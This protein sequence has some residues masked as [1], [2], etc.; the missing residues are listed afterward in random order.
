MGPN[1]EREIADRDLIVAYANRQL[2]GPVDGE[3]EYLPEQPHRRYLTGMLFP[4]ASDAATAVPLPDDI[5]DDAAGDVPGE[6]GEDQS[7]DPVSLAGQRLPS[8]VGVSFILPARVPIRI[9]L[10]AAR[11]RPE[12]I[13]WKR[14]PISLADENAV[15]ISPP[16][17]PCKTRTPVLDGA[18]TIDVNW[19]PF[20]GDAQLV[21]VTLVNRRALNEHGAA[22]PEDCLFQVALRC[23]PASGAIP[24]YPSVLGLQSDEEEEELAL[25]YRDVPTFAIGHGAA[26]VWAEERENEVDW[27]G[28]SYLPAYSVPQVNFTLNT[29][30]GVLSL[31]RL[32]G[33]LDDPSAID[34]LHVFVDG[35]ESWLN[36]FQDVIQQISPQFSEAAVRITSRVATAVGRMRR[37]VELLA[38]DEDPDMKTA[39]ALANRAML[40]QMAHATEAYAGKRKTRTAEL[41]PEPDYDGLENAWRP[42]QLAFLLLTIESAAHPSSPDRE[43][44]D[45]IWFP[46]GGGKTEAYLA[47]SAFT[48]FYRRLTLGDSGAGTAVMTRYTLRLLT[49]QQ[50]QRASTL[51]CACEVIR[52][53]DPGLLGSRPISIGIWIGG[54]NSPNTYVNAI[55]LF[56]KIKN[57]ERTTL[58]FQVDLCPWCGT[59]IIPDG[60]VADEAYGVQPSNGSFRMACP[61][62][63]CDFHDHLPVSSVDED[64]YDNPPTILIGTVDKF[65]RFTWEPRA[66]SL[67]GAGDTPGPS[68]IIQDE[69]HLISGPLGTIMGLYEAAFDVVMRASGAN[70]KVVA[71]TATI[72]RAE[73]Q[74]RGLFGRPL[75][76]FP[77]SGLN[78]DDSYFVRFDRALP[79]RLYCGVMPQ[80]HT[81]LT[82][83]VHL[84]SVLLQ[85]PLDAGISEPGLDAYW[86]LVAYH[87]NLMELGK[88]I[89]L[90]H[91]DIPAR[92]SVIAD[93]EDHVR[94]LSDDT[95]MELTSNVPAAEIPGRLE[96]LNRPST[97]ADPVSFVACTNMISVGV[98]VPRLG[99]MLVSGQ[100]K[101]TS[102]YIQ[103]TSRVGRRIPGLVFTLFSP[104][105]PRDRSHYESF[106]PYH[107]ALYKAVEPTSVTPFSIP[108]RARAL[109]ADLVVLARHA[110]GWAENDEAGK[111]DPANPG[112]LSLI[113]QFLERIERSDLEES[114]HIRQH[115]QELESIWTQRA[116]MA[117]SAGG[118]RYKSTGK[119]HVGLLR[120]FENEGPEW[121]TLNSMRNIDVEVRMRVRGEDNLWA[122][123][124]SVALRQRAWPG[125][126]RSSMSLASPSSRKTLLVGRVSGSYL[127]LPG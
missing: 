98:D 90:A 54:N 49:A 81:P 104:A 95:I 16:A 75:A 121:A 34:G 117:A 92:L 71:S 111:F 26:A 20:G 57:K 41:P 7:E 29:A 9:E 127:R 116:G 30:G 1:A 52:R 53:E 17:N 89:T 46:T 67:L 59:E 106:V 76:V 107:S 73:Q 109:H 103:A 55:E 79:G 115:I 66:G 113:G 39:F 80:G 23:R 94:G 60:E 40:M 42:F 97:E 2:I 4:V 25:V 12:G 35:Y 83:M 62:P 28:T 21:T 48:I 31:R 99:L 65:A 93:A 74:V 112:W 77:P 51:V 88:T 68:L 120:S 22:N 45:L 38:S 32:S 70:P 125:W 124:S 33:I 13:G 123:V 19:R 108:A 91:D 10:T 87:N 100:P 63:G 119:Q 24:P 85:A 118:L 86:T 72:R 64:I 110:Q 50:F 126:D 102:E 58:S 82:A 84:S 14:E 36:S 56:E 78:A 6:F 43:L 5:Q 105:R 44:V 61:N 3:F 47:L 27:V 8:A 114:D 69:L 101:T 122:N 37:G 96:A 11:Y 15:L 18:V